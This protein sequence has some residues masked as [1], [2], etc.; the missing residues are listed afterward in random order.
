M[1]M[2]YLRTYGVMAHTLGMRSRWVPASWLNQRK[3][4]YSSHLEMIIFSCAF[5]ML[6]HGN[7]DLSRVK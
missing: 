7:Y 2:I 5:R 4:R 6:L 3:E 1:H